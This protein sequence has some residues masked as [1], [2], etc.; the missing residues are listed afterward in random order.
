MN[1]YKSAP[2]CLIKN[3]QQQLPTLMSP[4]RLALW[5]KKFHVLFC[6]SPSQLLQMFFNLRSHLFE[7]CVRLSMQRN[8]IRN[9]AVVTSA[10][11][12]QVSRKQPTMNQ[13]IKSFY[14]N[15]LQGRKHE[16]LLQTVA[17]FLAHLIIHT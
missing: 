1:I 7:K 15:Q 16:A 8:N 6:I 14:I 4:A 9:T 13:D 3:T 2:S 11:V 5:Q 10:V 17:V 12:T